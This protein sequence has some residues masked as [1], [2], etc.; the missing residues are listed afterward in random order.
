M[1]GGRDR[2]DN[3]NIAGDWMHVHHNTFLGAVQAVNIRGVPSQH[4]LVHNNWFVQKTPVEAVVS[5]GNTRTYDN[6]YGEDRTP[7]GEEI[8]L[9]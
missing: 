8:V 1:H 7:Q 3:T 6:V 2:G 5:G 9:P 4:A